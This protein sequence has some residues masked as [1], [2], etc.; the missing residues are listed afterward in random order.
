VSRAAAVNGD[1]NPAERDPHSLSVKDTWNT[2]VKHS[3]Y[4][5]EN[6]LMI[7]FC[8]CCVTAWTVNSHKS[9]TL[10]SEINRVYFG[11]PFEAKL[12]EKRHMTNV[13][14]NNYVTCLPRAC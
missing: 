11:E 13:Y 5:E 2:V 10:I 4:V 6:Q 7:M 1:G 9:V 14:I 12:R 3:T 8:R